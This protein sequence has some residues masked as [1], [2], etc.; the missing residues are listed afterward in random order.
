[1][2]KSNV[3]IFIMVFIGVIIGTVFLSSSSNQTAAQ[4]TTLNIVNQTIT[5]SSTS[6]FTEITGRE[7]IA[8]TEIYNATGVTQNLLSQG[9]VTLVSALGS[10]GL[11]S[12][13]AKVNDTT[14]KI[15]LGRA[16]NVSYTANPDGYVGGAAGT[17]NRSTLIF[18]AL[19]I[20]IF[21][22][23][24]LLFT[25]PEYRKLVGLRG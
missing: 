1:M 5:L 16:V 14:G 2:A 24:V 9:N 23:V 19:G 15:F 12:V 8:V 7:L 4:S 25:S 17:I 11:L 3:T 13:N 22:I 6:N 20:L 21:A 18:G 10:D